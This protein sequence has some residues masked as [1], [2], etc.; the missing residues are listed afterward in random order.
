MRRMLK[1]TVEKIA[2]IFFLIIL[3][4]VRNGSNKINSIKKHDN[5]FVIFHCIPMSYVI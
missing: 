3:M 1:C 4:R 2:K 5:L